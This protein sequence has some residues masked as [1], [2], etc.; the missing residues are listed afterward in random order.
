MTTS[1][2]GYSYDV[3][4]IYVGAETLHADPLMPGEYLLPANATLIKPPS[5][6]DN[7]THGW[8]GSTWIET[9]DYRG[10]T[11]Y[12]IFTAAPSIIQTVG[13]I[14]SFYTLISPASIPFPKWT[15]VAW[16]T[17]TIVQADNAHNILI[18]SA[19][20]ALVVSDKV[21]IRCAKKGISFTTWLTYDAALVAIV[22]GTDTTSTTLPEMPAYPAGS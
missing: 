3:H 22:N 18:Q 9:L 16:I 13:E 20:A 2:F 15:G 10:Q 12:N 11:A 17:D 8:D 19:I 1:Q 5:A 21:A 4:G 14:G 6:A 7:I